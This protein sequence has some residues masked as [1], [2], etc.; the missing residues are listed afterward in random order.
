MKGERKSL[1]GHALAML[2]AQLWEQWRISRLELLIRMLFAGA[3]LILLSVAIVNVDDA[4]NQV[5]R[6][7]LI[8][9]IGFAALFSASWT[10]EFDR[11]QLG[12]TYRLGFARPIATGQLVIVPIFYSL[13]WSLIFYIGG[14]LAIYLP[15]GFT[16][17]LVGPSAI[18]ACT[19]CTL[20]AGA[21]MPTRIEG[22]IIGMVGA[23]AATVGWLGLR[24]YCSNDPD[25][26][27][28]SI[29]KA[30]YFDLAWYEYLGLVI[31]GSLSIWATIKSVDLQRHGEALLS[32]ISNSRLIRVDVRSL[33][34]TSAES[35]TSQA[36]TS[37][38]IES[39]RWLSFKSRSGAQTWYEVRRSAPLLLAACLI[40]PTALFAFLCIN[41][42]WELAPRVWLGALVVVPIVFQLLAADST[43]GITHK[44][45]LVCLSPFDA[46]RPMRC[47]QLIG[48]KVLVV[49]GWS[50]CGFL[51]I[52]IFA[53]LFALLSGEY[54][55][56]LRDFRTIQGAVG[57]VSLVWW[58]VGV[59]DL[60]F[61]FLS[62]TTLLFAQ[63]LW[64]SRYPQVL[65]AGSL[66][67]LAHVGLFAWDAAHGWPWELWWRC[68]GYVL[69]AAVIVGS[70]IA[71]VLAIRAGYLGKLYFGMAL[72]AWLVYV[73]STV[74]LLASS[75][76]PQP[77]AFVAY[78]V[79]AALLIVPLASAA[80]APL[81][82]AAHRHG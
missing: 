80:F 11:R 26:I 31:V 76:P 37:P 20:I 17:P 70:L 5:L 81:A 56:W 7:I 57:N 15:T 43:L 28:L 55:Y 71:L 36:V 22:R 61:I 42:H 72:G 25:P 13:C 50:L 51:L 1:Y 18:I 38:S 40:L 32:S 52:A 35:N 16:L 49:F 75:S 69:P 12:F 82:L 4:V 33:N 21:W 48:I 34:P 67:L 41:V 65:L 60:L 73:A 77:I 27:L 10:S 30:G 29:G 63:A 45:G 68:Y 14:A 59:I 74:G 66:L 23:V 9:I 3:I 24:D 6:G 53:G 64:M 8:F 78:L 58:V 47:D 62:S 46:T 44:Q 79:G 54:E 19:V 39:V 2:R